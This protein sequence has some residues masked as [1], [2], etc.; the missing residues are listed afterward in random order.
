VRRQVTLPRAC[1]TASG[2]IT[3]TASAATA[4]VRNVSAGRSAM[5]PIS[6]IAVM[7]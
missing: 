2:A 4:I 5:T 7:I 6:T 1:T 3:I